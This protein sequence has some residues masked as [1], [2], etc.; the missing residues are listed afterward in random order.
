ML[1]T[2]HQSVG[3]FARRQHNRTNRRGIPASAVERK[4]PSEATLVGKFELR[5]AADV[6]VDG[7]DRKSTRLNSS[8]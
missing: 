3:D 7:G 2:V 4:L 1:V 8:H 6:A 5:S